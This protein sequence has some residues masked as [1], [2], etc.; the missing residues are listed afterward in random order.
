MTSGSGFI[1]PQRKQVQ[2]NPIKELPKLF[3]GALA[4]FSV[5]S[6]GTASLN[7]II[8]ASGMSKGSFYHKFADKLDLY[9]CL[10][11][12]V[13]ADKVEFF[14]QRFQSMDMP[15][16]FFE[17]IRFIAR[18]GMEFAMREP[19]Y[20]ALTRTYLAES[21]EIK[22][23]VKA[24]FPTRGMDQMEHLVGTAYEKHQ[25]RDNFSKKFIKDIIAL[26]LYNLDALIEE[27]MEL[28]DMVQKIDDLVEMLKNGLEKIN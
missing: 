26:L 7:D 23:A 22:E 2:E 15:T 6:Y 21:H 1:R 27:G 11:D 14:A 17:Q 18:L 8:K 3:D 4:E 10:M 12:K 13:T 24:A 25:F 19:R 28:I 5:K 16:D 9:L 20:Q